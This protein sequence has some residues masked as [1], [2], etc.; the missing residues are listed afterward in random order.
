ME[1]IILAISVSFVAFLSTSIDNLFLLVTL[2]LHS[3]YGT[4]KVRAG[5]LLAIV[6]MLIICLVLAQSA[7]LMPEKLIP[8]IG[9]VPLGIGLYELYQLIIN[10]EDSSSFAH[11]GLEAGKGTVWA[12]AIIMLTHSWDSIGVLAPLFADTKTT[13]LPWMAASVVTT[14]ILLILTG[15]WAVSHP[16]VRQILAKIA[17]KILPFLLIGVGLY[18]LTNTPTDVT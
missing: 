3:K 11:E 14:G 5:Y 17:P 10:K 8:Y 6:L 16:R 4:N 18:I 12:I 2:S 15:Q 7:Q 13:L 1:D 9:L